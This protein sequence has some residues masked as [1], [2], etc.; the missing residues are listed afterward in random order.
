MAKI[1]I[2]TSA[3]SAY[4]WLAVWYSMSYLVLGAGAL[5]HKKYTSYLVLGGQ[6]VIKE[7]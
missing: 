2:N 1:I 7:Q 5:S 3:A 4:A 6:R